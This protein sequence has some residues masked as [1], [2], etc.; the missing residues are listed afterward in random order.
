MYA[1]DFATAVSTAQALIKEDPRIDIAC[2]PLAMEAL[3][4]GDVARARRTFEQAAGAGEAGA[5]VSVLGLADVAMFEGRYAD[6]IA[7]LPPA[8]LRDEAQGNSVGAAAKLV[9]LSEAH[10]ARQETRQ[11]DATIARIRTLSIQDSALVPVA[12]LAVAAGRVGE[13]RAIASELAA[14]LPAQSARMAN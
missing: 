6:A 1:G 13:A 10:A 8:V 5:S 7:S 11:R 9:A 3:N 2:L 14:R 12:R 4:S